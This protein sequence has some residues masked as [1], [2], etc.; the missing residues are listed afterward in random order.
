MTHVQNFDMSY[1]LRHPYL[2]RS[3]D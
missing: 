2:P 3:P 1:T